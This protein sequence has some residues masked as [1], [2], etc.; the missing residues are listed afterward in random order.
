MSGPT[1]KSW[2]TEA[3]QEQA[4]V[5]QGLNTEYHKTHRTDQNKTQPIRSHQ[6]RAN[7]QNETRA[8]RSRANPGLTRRWAR[9]LI[10]FDAK[11]FELEG[12]RD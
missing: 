5:K 4:W 1:F 8:F 3:K 11:R 10:C 9:R 6:L 7:T 2:S 12:K